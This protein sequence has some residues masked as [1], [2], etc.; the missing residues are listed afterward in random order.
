MTNKRGIAFHRSN[1][2]VG[3]FSGTLEQ[4]I[5]SEQPE[6]PNEEP[7]PYPV[8]GI[9]FE[10]DDEELEVNE[11]EEIEVEEEEFIN[12]PEEVLY[13]AGIKMDE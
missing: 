1:G 9:Q 4:L 6:S 13:P 10:D 5:A 8:A 7:L 2:N 3:H 11:D 12:M